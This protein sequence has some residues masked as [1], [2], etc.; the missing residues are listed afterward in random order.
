MH[1]VVWA[2]WFF[3]DPL[4]LAESSTS[5]G[6]LGRDLLEHEDEGLI[7]RSR[8]RQA[9]KAITEAHLRINGEG[10]RGWGNEPI[11]AEMSLE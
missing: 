10:K 5:E 6:A 2:A 11:A 8:H 7:T 3:P 9:S 1:A 4:W